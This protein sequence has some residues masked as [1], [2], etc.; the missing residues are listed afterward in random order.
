ML[1][2]FLSLNGQFLEFLR[3]LDIIIF[4]SHHINEF[5]YSAGR[6][7]K[8]LKKEKDRWARKKGGIDKQDSRANRKRKSEIK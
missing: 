4:V 8:S 3:A 6:G 1:I 5:L 2:P 7:E